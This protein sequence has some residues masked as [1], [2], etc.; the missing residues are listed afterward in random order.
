MQPVHHAALQQQSLSNSGNSLAA[1]FLLPRPIPAEATWCLQVAWQQ[2][3]YST[4]GHLSF[5]PHPCAPMTVSVQAAPAAR[6]AGSPTS[7]L[8][9]CQRPS[10]TP[11]RASMACSPL[12]SA[13][14]R[15]R[16]SICSIAHPSMI[17]RRLPRRALHRIS[18]HPWGSL[19]LMQPSSLLS[20]AQQMQGTAQT[21]AGTLH[22]GACRRL[23][24][25]LCMAILPAQLQKLQGTHQL[26]TLGD[27]MLLT[28]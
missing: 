9:L 4:P 18:T 6:A 17:S 25:P 5:R 11:G 16:T 15:L 12:R 14:R 7:P 26:Q 27:I 21:S 8:L 20:A 24:I 10:M 28:S 1:S 3:T 13:Q 22:T 23:A 19:E 2:R